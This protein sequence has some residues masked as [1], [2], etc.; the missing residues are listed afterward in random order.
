MKTEK[1]LTKVD[2]FIL[3]DRR[4]FEKALASSEAKIKELQEV[5][6]DNGEMVGEKEAEIAEKEQIISKL[7]HAIG[8]IVVILD[9]QKDGDTITK[10]DKELDFIHNDYRR[11]IAEKEKEIQEL[12][13]DVP[14]CDDC[15]VK[16]DAKKEIAEFQKRVEF[17][18]I[19]KKEFIH[20]LAIAADEIAKLKSDKEYYINQNRLNIEESKR[21]KSE[22]AEL[23]GFIE[24]SKEYEM[25]DGK[26]TGKWWVHFDSHN[27]KWG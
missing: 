5:C 17:L 11:I 7:I 12:R 23:L 18:R 3:K 10:K 20:K 22:K 15:L 9:I 1:P 2:K 8:R 14:D 13:K 6:E 16:E 21:L 26:F 4:Y 27:W 19:P 24:Q 25:V